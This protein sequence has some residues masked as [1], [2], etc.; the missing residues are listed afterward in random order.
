MKL[1]E[2]KK[3]EG[4]PVS[5][6]LRDLAKIIEDKKMDVSS[7]LCV[8]VHPVEDGVGIRLCSLGRELSYLEM[9]GALFQASKEIGSD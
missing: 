8:G 5:E 3:K 7:M 9:V 2:M 1:V 4:H 6:A